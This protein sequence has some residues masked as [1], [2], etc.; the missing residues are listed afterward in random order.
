MRPRCEPIRCWRRSTPG[1]DSVVN[2]NEP[3]DYQQARARPA[4]EVTIQRFGP[5]ADG[6]RGPQQVRRQPW[7]RPRPP[8]GWLWTGMWWRR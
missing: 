1:L 3:A 5:L 4:P 8:P 7:P 6:H 2:V